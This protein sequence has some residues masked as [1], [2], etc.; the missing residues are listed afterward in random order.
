[1]RLLIVHRT[2]Y[3]YSE[4][5]T[6]NYNEVRLQPVSD[7]T[8]EC[9]QFA[10]VTEPEAR[11][12]RY[13]DFH[14]NLVDHFFV[15]D[16]H[17]ELAVESRSEVTTY[18]RPAGEPAPE[19]PLSR[20]EECLRLEQCYDFLQ[21]STYVDL[22]VEMWRMA[23]DAVSGA[24][25]AWA[26]AVSMMAWVHREFA[27]DAAATTVH[28]RLREVMRLRRGVC[29]DLAHVLIGLCRSVRLPARYVSGYLYVGEDTVL[30]GDLASHAWVEVY[31]PGFGWRALDPT[32]N[33]AADRHHVKVAVGRDY[34]D[35]APLRGTFKGRATQQ[36]M[37][38]LE[39]RR[40]DGPGLEGAGAGIPG[41]VAGRQ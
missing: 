30:R 17:R 1:M 36:M 23:Q 34:A 22:D 24:E 15:G 40:I 33:R 6:E 11:V 41:P 28:T 8:Q 39:I 31:L 19:F 13:H 3:R 25:D 18:G 26:A 29:Q 32:N 38:D 7:E 14:L 9:H 4:P 16:A 21:K 27:Y 2:R 10:L 5:V 12:Q 37:V 35:A 20:I